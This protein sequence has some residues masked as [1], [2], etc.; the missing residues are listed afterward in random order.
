LTAYREEINLYLRSAVRLYGHITPRKFLQIFNRFHKDHKLYKAD[1]EKWM[2]KLN[3]HAETYRIYTN[4]IINTTVPVEVINQ[5]IDNQEGK[6]FQI[7]ETAEAFTAWASPS[8]YPE[9]EE[10]T[11]LRDYL[12][13]ECKVPI[14]AIPSLMNDIAQ[15]VM[16][17]RDA[18][19]ETDVFLEYGVLQSLNEDQLDELYSRFVDFTNGIIHW[20]NCG[21]TPTEL[22]HMYMEA[23]KAEAEAKDPQSHGCCKRQN[24][25]D[26]IRF[27]FCFSGALR[28]EWHTEGTRQGRR[29]PPTRRQDKRSASAGTVLRM[30]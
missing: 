14:A 12:L 8:Y 6:E 21:C 16:E 15:A 9:S 22:F 11:L 2:N 25:T 17:D 27:C 19:Y 10:A 18:D 29:L 13:S 1:L 24:L 7:P 23:E 4:A 5:T 28:I 30:P 3:Y 20:A 26:S